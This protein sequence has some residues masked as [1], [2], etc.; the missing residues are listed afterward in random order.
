MDDVII[1]PEEV[2]D[3]TAR[4]V[5]RDGTKSATQKGFLCNLQSRQQPFNRG[6]IVDDKLYDDI[7]S[8]CMEYK[9]TKGRASGKGDSKYDALK[10]RINDMAKRLDQRKRDESRMYLTSMPSFDAIQKGRYGIERG[11]LYKHGRTK[12]HKSHKIHSVENLPGYFATW[13]GQLRDGATWNDLVEYGVSTLSIDKHVLDYFRADFKIVESDK[14]QDTASRKRQKIQRPG[15]VTTNSETNGSTGTTVSTDETQAS[16]PRSDA[17]SNGINAVSTDHSAHAVD[18][19]VQQGDNH[20]ITNTLESLQNNFVLNA[21]AMTDVFLY[22]WML[23]RIPVMEE[24]IRQ[25]QEQ[26]RRIPVLDEQIQRM[27]E[28]TQLI[29]MEEQIRRMEQQI[30]GVSVMAEYI[31]RIPLCKNK[32]NGWMWKFNSFVV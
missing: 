26:T 18:S 8:A 23:Q 28:K 22:S 3:D 15:N 27:E 16:L 13:Y 31:R 7:F 17:L 2:Y 4:V 14:G 25:T 32:S 11:E 19:P 21:P 6:V 9:N 10:E 24:Q 12:Q 30:R 5:C 29:A 20:G 1:A